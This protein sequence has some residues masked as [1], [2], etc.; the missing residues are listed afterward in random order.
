MP[1]HNDLK[2]I[3]ELFPPN[4]KSELPVAFF[5]AKNN[6]TKKNSVSIENSLPYNT[7]QLACYWF[8][9]PLS[10]MYKYLEDETLDSYS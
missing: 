4:W 8:H 5:H 3:L 10:Q 2:D 7:T 6:S 9:K 1:E